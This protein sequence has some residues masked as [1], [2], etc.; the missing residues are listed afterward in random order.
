M[1][2]RSLALK[3]D[4]DHPRIWWTSF[5]PLDWIGIVLL[6]VCTVC[7]SLWSGAYYVVQQLNE[8]KSSVAVLR[9]ERDG[10][11]EELAKFHDTTNEIKADVKGLQ[12][13]VHALDNRLARS[14]AQRK[15]CP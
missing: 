1:N 14:E 7:G 2:Q 8:I 15:E 3:A 11:R 6:V 12:G 5:S 10:D 9:V 4:V 13:A